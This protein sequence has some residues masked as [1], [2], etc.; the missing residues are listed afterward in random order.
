MYIEVAI[1]R[2]ILQQNRTSAHPTPPANTSNTPAAV[3]LTG[4][5]APACAD[6]A[7]GSE[8]LVPEAETVDEVVATPVAEEG[9]SEVTACASARSGAWK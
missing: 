7:G 4:E 8:A 6:E 3:S 1:S 9:A 2:L 5:A